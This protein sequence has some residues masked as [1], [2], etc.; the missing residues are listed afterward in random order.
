[1]MEKPF[2]F[3]PNQLKE[4]AQKHKTAYAQA[5]PF[6]HVVIDNFLPE[7]LLDE[8]LT[9]FLPTE[10]KDY[11]QYDG[12]AEKKLMA[13]SENALGLTTRHLIARFNSSAFVD[14]LENLTGIGGLIPDPHLIGGG[15]HRIVKGGFL[16]VHTD[17]NWY[18]RLKLDRRVNLLLY[19]NKD[20]K[21]EYGGHLELWNS[22][23]TL[24]E[25]KILPIFNRLVI[26]SS[27]NNSYHGHPSPLTCPPDRS[28]QSLALYY[29]SNGRPEEEK[30]EAHATIFRPRPGEVFEREVVPMSQR[31]DKA[32]RGVVKK[33]LPPILFDFLKYIKNR[34]SRSGGVD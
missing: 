26:F 9:E 3:D 19:L 29:Y 33:C 11:F 1:M 22:D 16:K 20:W 10:S 18:S 27:T 8:I 5:K 15:L 17:Y 6:P 13:Q 32:L 34:I 23:M 14:F 21:E 30:S 2:F 24:C 4:I 12:P 31:L 28:R 25:Q 7:N